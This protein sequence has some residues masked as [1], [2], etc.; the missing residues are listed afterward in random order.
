MATQKRIYIDT[1]IPSAYY[2]LR[3][4]DESLTRQRATRQWWEKYTDLLTITSSI[5]VI[6][7]LSRGEHNIKKDRLDLL[8]DIELF[9]SSSEIQE[10][11]QVYIDR[12]VM[13]QDPFGDAHHLA[14]AS[15]HKLDVLLTWNCLHLANP[16]KL[17]LIT[18]INKEL[19]LSTPELTTPFTFLGDND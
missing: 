2:T 1:S 13:P 7:E 15:F 6:L 12:L 5:V 9:E 18:Q 8:K 17:N 11:V 19:G 4:D 14:I 16:N 10:I 3:T